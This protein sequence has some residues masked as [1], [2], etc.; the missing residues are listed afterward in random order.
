MLAQQAAVGQ[1]GER[2]VERQALD[3][4]LGGLA[5]RDVDEG[6]DAADD[7]GAAHDRVR[8]VFDRKTGTVRAPE[9]PVVDMGARAVGGRRGRGGRRFRIVEARD[10]AEPAAEQLL[11]AVVAEHAHGG[12]VG[13]RAGAARVG[14]EQAFGR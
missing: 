6:H 11:L 4:R 10:L 2:V 13:E 7:I 5:L 1:I 8:P 12:R 9:H 3:R 14:G